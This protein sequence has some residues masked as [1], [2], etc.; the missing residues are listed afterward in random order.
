MLGIGFELV[1]EIIFK[2]CAGAGQQWLMPAIL[3]TWEAEIRRMEVP[4]QPGQ[5]VHKTPSPK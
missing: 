4:G 5:I 2:I 1:V 3:A